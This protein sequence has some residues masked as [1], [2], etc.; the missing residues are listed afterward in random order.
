MVFIFYSVDALSDIIYEIGDN[1]GVCYIGG[2]YINSF[3]ERERI[4]SKILFVKGQWESTHLPFPPANTFQV[5][6]Q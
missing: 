4:S 3:Y 6:F 5:V 2:D 1:N